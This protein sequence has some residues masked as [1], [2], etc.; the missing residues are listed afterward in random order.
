MGIP[1]VLMRTGKWGRIRML[2][3]F[4]CILGLWITVLLD[5]IRHSTDIVHIDSQRADLLHGT[6]EAG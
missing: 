2:H 6:L 1:F 5:I 4:P 3:R